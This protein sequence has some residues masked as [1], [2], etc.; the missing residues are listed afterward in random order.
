MAPGGSPWEW[1]PQQQPPQQQQQQQGQPRRWRDGSVGYSDWSGGG[2]GGKHYGNGREYYRERDGP[3]EREWDGGGDTPP[4]PPPPRNDREREREPPRGS[5][6]SPWS[7][8]SQ[9]Y[10]PPAVG[11]CG[12]VVPRRKCALHGSVRSQAYMAEIGQETWICRADDVCRTSVTDRL[13]YSMRDP[14]NAEALRR[15]LSRAGSAADGVCPVKLGE[16]LR[17]RTVDPPATGSKCSRLCW[18]WLTRRECPGQFSEISCPFA[19]DEAD[20]DLPRSNG[21]MQLMLLLRLSLV[22]PPPQTGP[23]TREG[24]PPRTGSALEQQEERLVAAAVDQLT[25]GTVERAA[26]CLHSMQHKAPAAAEAVSRRLQRHGD[27]C[28][29]LLQAVYLV[30]VATTSPKEPQAALRTADG[31]RRHLVRLFADTRR[32]ALKEGPEMAREIDEHLR[33]VTECWRRVDTFDLR[34]LAAL[35]E[36]TDPAGGQQHAAQQP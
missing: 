15:V 30:A 24:G 25:A 3:R 35:D 9:P 28:G 14:E 2:G 27:D 11:V 34:L 23:W 18:H 10:P 22:N 36:R 16:V 20:L 7:T 31:F 32:A 33:Q 8:G 6:T 29:K 13:S 4:A 12:D 17:V 26:A 5:P 19:H 1:R 21:L